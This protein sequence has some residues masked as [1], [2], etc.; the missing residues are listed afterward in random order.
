MN[1]SSGHIHPASHF[2]G[3]FS[4]IAVYGKNTFW[5]QGIFWLQYFEW[6]LGKNLYSFL[7]K[8]QSY[9]IIII[10]INI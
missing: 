10:N 8:H 3:L 4:Y 7:T 2:E 6:P 1:H 5:A 9:V